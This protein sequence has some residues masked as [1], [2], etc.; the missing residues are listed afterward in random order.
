MNRYEKTSGCL[1]FIILNWC[2]NMNNY[3]CM[4]QLLSYG[5]KQFTV[6]QCSCVASHEQPSIIWADKKERAENKP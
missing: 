6:G 1:K 5:Y 2:L 4:L 3:K